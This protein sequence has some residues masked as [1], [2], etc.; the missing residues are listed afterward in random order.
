[1][2]DSPKPPTLAASDL[3]MGPSCLGSPARINCGEDREKSM[4]LAKLLITSGSVACPKRNNYSNSTIEAMVCIREKECT[5][6]V[7][8]YDIEMPCGDGIVLQIG[9][10]GTRRDDVLVSQ[11]HFHFGEDE[12]TIVDIILTVIQ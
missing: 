9:S 7:N 11:K 10:H 12:A 6:F 3:T 1:M 8:E 5:C 2:N 4:R